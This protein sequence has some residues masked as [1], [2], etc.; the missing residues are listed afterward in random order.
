M[1]YR[2]LIFTFAAL[3]FLSSCANLSPTFDDPEIKVTSFKLVPSNSIN[4]KFEI[5][6]NVINPNNTNI[7]LQGLAYTARI[8][9]QKVFSGVASELSPIKA[10]GS[11]D[12][13]LGGQADLL[14]GLALIN[15]LLSMEKLNQPINYSL[16][17]KMNIKGL[18]IPITLERTGELTLPNQLR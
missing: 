13:T 10:Y 12:I 16:N 7:N 6:L 17:V 2:Y 1:P 3:L 5:G 18:L 8:E 15:K 14:G 9:G 11:A 4:P